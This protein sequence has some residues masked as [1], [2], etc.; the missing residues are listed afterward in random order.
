MIDNCSDSGKSCDTPNPV[1]SK[2][3]TGGIAADTFSCVNGNAYYLVTATGPV[4][5]TGGNII[6]L[7][8]IS[9]NTFTA[10]PGITHS[11]LY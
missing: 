4:A 6:G 5:N 3:I 7:A 9:Y 1:D 11:P 10:L 8:P 2:F